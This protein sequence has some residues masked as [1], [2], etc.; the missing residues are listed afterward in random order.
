MTARCLVC[1]TNPP[2]PLPYPIPEGHEV[3][4]S[5]MMADKSLYCVECFEE[6]DHT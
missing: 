4:W 6:A 5:E 3:M 2:R 1:E